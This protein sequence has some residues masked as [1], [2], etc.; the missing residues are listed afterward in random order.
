MYDEMVGRQ[1]M[2]GREGLLDC[3]RARLVPVT[4]MK[5]PSSFEVFVEVFSSG[6]SI[7]NSR[8]CDTFAF[9]TNHRT[10]TIAMSRQQQFRNTPR[11]PLRGGVPAYIWAPVAA[12]TGGV[13]YG[14]YSHVD[15]VPLTKRKRFLATSPEFE[16]N[17]GDQQ[18]KA[19][20]KDY[21]GKVLPESHRA[22]QTVHRVG[23]RIAT[24]TQ[25]FCK[26]HNLNH[27]ADKPFTYTVVRSDQ[28][29]AFVLPGNHIFVL[30]GLFRYVRDE[31]DLAAVLGH[32]MAHN[33]AR[34]VG[35]RVSGT[36]V[37]NIIASLLYLVDPSGYM[38]AIFMPAANLLHDLPHSREN[39]S[40]ADR[41]GVELSARACYDPKAAKRVF[42]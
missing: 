30:T 7:S 18:Y 26:Q 15:E 16:R 39:E 2:S 10:T 32:E 19:L 12:I 27:M 21:K 38:S 3:R 24:A 33:V 36:L 42:S 20:L 23:S 6:M 22:S 41:I 13:L 35:E 1:E 29:N 17:I 25:D 11:P 40:E 34:H 9:K 8:N 14:Y 37:V 28:A 5:S 4:V 31:D